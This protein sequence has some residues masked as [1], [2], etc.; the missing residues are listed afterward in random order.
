MESEAKRGKS[1]DNNSG[2]DSSADEAAGR[3]FGRAAH[4]AKKQKS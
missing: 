2:A 4:K 3:E 1:N